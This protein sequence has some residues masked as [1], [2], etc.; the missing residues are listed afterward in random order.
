[1]PSVFLELVRLR[2]SHSQSYD[3]LIA[4]P[5]TVWPALRDV[6]G[7]IVTRR[8][9][10]SGQFYSQCSEGGA[11]TLNFKQITQTA[12]L[13]MLDIVQSKGT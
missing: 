2:T 4:M 1:M 9:A 7:P 6:C 13:L 12:L 5:P 10:I 11:L 3:S 8:G